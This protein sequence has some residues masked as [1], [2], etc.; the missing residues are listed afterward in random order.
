MDLQKLYYFRTVAKLEHMTQAAR[1]L[2]IAQP[3][4]SKTIGMLE[5]ELGVPLFDRQ[6]RRIRLNAY[7]RTYLEYVETALAALEEGRRRI[8]DMAGMERGTV[9][10][11]TVTMKRFAELLGAFRSA[12]PAV[13]IR[14]TQT[15]PEQMPAILQSGS[16]DFGYTPSRIDDP[17]LADRP[18]LREEIFLAV[19]PGH[20]F[21]D[22]DGI[23]L[24]AAADEPF[25]SLKEGYHF[26]ALTDE[27]CRGAGFTPN[28]VCEVDEPSAVRSLVRAGLGVALLPA[29]RSDEEYPLVLLPIKGKPFRR[30]FYLAWHKDRYLSLAAQRFRDF[31]IA[32]FRDWQAEQGEQPPLPARVKTDGGARYD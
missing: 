25:I 27:L 19:P 15:S 6:G 1:E 23:D 21:A 18:L 11:A 8:A 31:A 14:V 29:C 26:R 16:I 13:T 12:Y 24:H 30:T 4:L 32:H 22:R 7:G 10:L 28:I 3:A 17:G 20:P 2:K 9:H 5:E